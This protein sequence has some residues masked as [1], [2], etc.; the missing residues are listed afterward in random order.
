MYFSVICS[1]CFEMNRSLKKETP[2]GRLGKWHFI[3]GT[4]LILY[5]K[6]G[7]KENSSRPLLVQLPQKTGGA[8][9]EVTGHVEPLSNTEAWPSQ[10]AAAPPPG[11]VPAV[12]PRAPPAAWRTCDAGQAPTRSRGLFMGHG[13]PRFHPRSADQSLWGRGNQGSAW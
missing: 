11:R 10:P 12:P 6:Q 9:G 4:R 13:I 1:K 5:G 3:N 2:A 7:H 8:A